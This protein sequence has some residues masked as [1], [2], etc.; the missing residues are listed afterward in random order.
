VAPV[1]VGVA[2]ARS[3]SA[4][5][6]DVSLGAMAGAILLQI[7]S[8]LAN[9]V[10]DY[11]KG[12]DTEQRLG[13]TRAAQ[14]GLL[15]SRAIKRALFGVLLMAMG[16][17]TW[18]GS[19][20]GWPVIAVGSAAI[21]S[22]IAYTGGPFPLGYHGLGDI[23]VF[24]FF[25]PVAVGTTAWLEGA[26][27]GPKVLLLGC[28]MGVLCVNILVV[29]NLRDVQQDRTAG[30]RTLVVRFGTRAGQ[31]QYAGLMFLAYGLV[32]TGVATGSLPL[33]CSLVLA[34]VPVSVRLSER[35]GRET[36]RAMNE[37]LARTAQHLLLFAVLLS[38]GLWVKMP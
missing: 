33:A 3:D 35:V 29:N 21:L 7:A 15:S 14:S 16:V 2:T 1:L 28:V 25:G 13:P 36:G 4:F 5:R 6:W 19:V 11:E 32:A 38:L 17:G 10:F 18:L 26:P 12:A 9:D 8:N 24:A 27:L 31:I 20:G 23:F 34:A 22:A 37:L 30:K